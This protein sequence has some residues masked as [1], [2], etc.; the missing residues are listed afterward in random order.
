MPGRLEDFMTGFLV[1]A[2]GRNVDGSLS[3]I[4]QWGRPVSLTIAGDGS[5]LVSD[6]QGGRI[7]QIRYR[8]PQR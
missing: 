2:G 6:D 5:L 4:T 8:N 1:T 7:W 3:P